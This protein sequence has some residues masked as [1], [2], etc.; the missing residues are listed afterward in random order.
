MINKIK[1]SLDP[2]WSDDIKNFINK[3]D[4]TTGVNTFSEIETIISAVD[5]H[6]FNPS[7]EYIYC[8]D[9]SSLCWFDSKKALK[10][11]NKQTK[12]L[13]Y[14]V[15]D[16]PNSN[17][18][19]KME[20]YE[21]IPKQTNNTTT[22]QS[23]TGNKEMDV[24]A[25]ESILANQFSQFESSITSKIELKIQTEVDKLRTELT[26]KIETEVSNL[27]N[28]IETELSKINERLDRLEH[29]VDVIFKILK[30]HDEALV[31]AGILKVSAFEEFGVEYEIDD[32]KK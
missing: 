6:H 26:S 17:L 30:R 11:F 27:N 10:D 19:I 29:K 15:I 1:L 18:G 25:L 20:L 5:K 3:F 22:T 21:K 16:I 24:T 8:V 7:E 32:K 4:I 2:S 12:L 14:N 28:K 23:Q 13:G 31:D 9:F